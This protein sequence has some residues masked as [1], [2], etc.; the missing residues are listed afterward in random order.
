MFDDPS[1]VDV[2]VASGT[3]NFEYIMKFVK[4]LRDGGLAVESN[5]MDRS[6]KAQFKYADKLGAR[7][8]ITIG[9]D[10]IASGEIS[11]KDMSKGEQIKL[12]NTEVMEYLNKCL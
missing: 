10:E 11:I 4:T 7:Y 3:D 6:L 2:Y 5:L 8:V 9:D 12:K 1:Q